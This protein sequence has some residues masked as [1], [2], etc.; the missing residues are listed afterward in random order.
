[1]VADLLVRHVITRHGAPHRLLSDQGSQFLSKVM[2]RVYHLLGINKRQTTAYHPQCDGLVERFNRTLTQ[3]LSMV[4]DTDNTDWDRMLPLVLFAYNTS[5]HT[6]THF[7][8]FELLYG[9]QAKLPVELSTGAPTADQVDPESLTDY[10]DQLRLRI[11]KSHEVART[12]LLAVAERYKQDYR[13]GRR[14]TNHTYTVGAKVWLYHPE[15][16]ERRCPK[17]L[18][19]WFG[20]YIITHQPG[21]VTFTIQAC[22]HLKKSRTV[23]ISRLKPYHDSLDRPQQHLVPVVTHRSDPDFMSPDQQQT[24][25]DRYEVEAILSRRVVPSHKSGKN[26]IQY[27]IKWKGYSPSQNSWEPEE[28]LDGCQQL[29]QEYLNT[30]A[31]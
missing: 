18:H 28:N 14:Q 3:M 6:A 27:L 20:P 2:Q 21:P 24:E 16:P 26:I 8:P 23:H 12:R 5:R 30:R 22:D 19:R 1:M 15:T 9:R 31:M 4:I 17:F 7:T 25:P 10:A 11:Q 13:K 29:L